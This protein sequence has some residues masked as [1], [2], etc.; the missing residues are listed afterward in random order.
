MRKGIVFTYAEA[1]G[2]VLIF[3]CSYAELHFF[4]SLTLSKL[5]KISHS[6][7]L[8]LIQGMCGYRHPASAIGTGKDLQSSGCFSLQTLF[9]S[10][11]KLPSALSMYL[12]YQALLFT[13]SNI[14]LAQL[15]QNVKSHTQKKQRLFTEVIFNI[16]MHRSTCK[17]RAL[18]K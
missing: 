7:Y 2:L 16:S 6:K 3:F 15:W 10:V 1:R 12:A 5:V 8:F 13:N 9:D 11:L 14:F 18:M 4:T 17:I